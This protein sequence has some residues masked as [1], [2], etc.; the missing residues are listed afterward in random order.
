MWNW[1]MLSITAQA[2][3]ADLLERALYNG[4]LATISLD[5]KKFF[6]TNPLKDVEGLPFE[7][8]W[9]RRREPYISCF[10]CPPNTVRTIAEVAAYAYSVSD[11]GVW[12]NLY[13]GN[14]L[15]TRLSNGPAIRL[16]QETDYP[17]A[18]TVRITLENA[19]QRECSL[20]LRIPAWAEQAR[21]AVNG[22][23]IATDLESG[24]YF[25]IKRSWSSGD[26]VELVLPMPVQLME[27]HPLVE[28]VRNQIA[29]QRG[30]IVY[31]LESIDLPEAIKPEQVAISPDAR[32]RH[33]FDAGLLDGITVL[34]GQAHVLAGDGWEDTLY[35]KLSTRDA[36]TI[37][38][39]LIP[40]YAWGNRG[41][42]EMTVWMPLR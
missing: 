23:S 8:R 36:Q 33:R 3:Y 28:E 35:R 39:R 6:Y 14:V 19:P 17:W 11:E 41:R 22:R 13:G 32:F 5:G 7:L 20:F 26:K 25:E 18:G 10:C 21:V 4:V 15:D 42:S 16:K 12:V 31:C 27:A 34:E 29:V 24:R 40:Y 2:R 30:P 37:D 38:V 1:R 9:S